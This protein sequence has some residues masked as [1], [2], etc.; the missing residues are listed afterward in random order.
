M[1]ADLKDGYPQPE[2]MAV[3]LRGLMA[4]LQDHQD[5]PDLAQQVPHE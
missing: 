5:D 3:M 2:H 1:A 4:A